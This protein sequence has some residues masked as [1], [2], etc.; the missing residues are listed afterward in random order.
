M[1]GL[2]EKRYKNEPLTLP[3]YDFFEE[4]KK[5]KK[6]DKASKRK[7]LNSKRSRKQKKD[8]YTINTFNHDYIS[9]SFMTDMGIRKR[10]LSNL[11]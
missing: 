1:I 8:F 5:D 11:S 4:L 9:P 6:K 10:K 7:G 3:K 2:V